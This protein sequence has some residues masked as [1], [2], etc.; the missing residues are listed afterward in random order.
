MSQILSAGGDSCSGGG[1]YP[2]LVPSIVGSLPFQQAR[3]LFG[4]YAACRFS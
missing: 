1:A 3:R 4:T 2:S